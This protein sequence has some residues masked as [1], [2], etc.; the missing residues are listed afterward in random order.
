MFKSRHVRLLAVAGTAA[1]VAASLTVQVSA[2]QAAPLGEVRSA[3]ATDRVAGSFI[4]KLKDSAEAISA[5]RATANEVAARHGGAVDKVFLSALR[6]FT[7]KNLSV[8]RAKRLAA[9]PAVEYVEQDQ[10][11][12]AEAVQTSPPSWGL[13]RIDQATLPLSGSYNYT[14]TG[15]GVT[16][17]V[18]DTGVRISHTTFGGRARNGYDFIDNDQVAQDGNGHGTHV[19]GTIAGSRYGVAKAAKIVAV[20][21]LNNEGG[22]TVAGVVAGI[23]WVT[24]NAVKPAVANMSLGGGAST[25]IDDAV[26]R[27]IASGVTF[28]V[29]AGN[30]SSDAG[31]YSP[32]RVTQAITVGYTDRTDARD[33]YSNFGSSLDLFAPGTDITSAWSTSDTATNTISGTS[34]ATPHVAGAIARYLQNNKTATPAQVSAA[35]ITAST[36]GKVVDAGA[37][38]PNRL[39]FI[40]PRS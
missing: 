20:R 25:A 8:S 3:D 10:A 17:Y 13:D 6:G 36:K 31:N 27:S 23:D 21:V 9:D 2:A 22:G 18:L 39:L 34:M 38:S 12:R 1:A 32:A 28:A 7:V 35:L 33:F 30:A 15:T 5:T 19:A 40:A 29:A 4:V 26:R 24:A 16:A 37:G 11:V 14:S